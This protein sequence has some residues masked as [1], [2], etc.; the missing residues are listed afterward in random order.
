MLE[1]RSRLEL[2]LGASEVRHGFGLFETLLVRRGAPLRLPWH[3]ERL[4]AGAAFLRMEAPPS[5]KVILDFA[6]SAFDL[7]SRDEA[8]LRLY[9]LG[10]CLFVDLGTSLPPLPPSRGAALSRSIRRW[11]ASPLCRFKTLS[12]MENRLL[13]REAQDRGLLEVVA[14]NESGRLSDGGRTSLFAV[15]GPRLLTPPVADGA[16]PGTLRRLL[17][18]RGLAREAPLSAS[19]MARAEAA[20]VCNAL[21]LVLPLEAWEGRSLDREASLLREAAALVDSES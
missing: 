7:A 9:A 21:R 16:L 3:L 1:L 19:D 10:P 11:S 6:R 12:Y 4:A 15:V 18:E 2:D 5:S 20:F 8:V 13:S 17:L 14:L